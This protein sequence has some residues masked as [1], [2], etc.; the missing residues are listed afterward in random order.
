MPELASRWLTDAER[1]LG[2][3]HK[4]RR[5][6]WAELVEA[7]GVC[8]ARCRLPILPGQ[9]W[10]LGHV[11]GSNRQLEAGPEHRH[12]RDCPE[13]GNRATR[14]RPQWR[15][16]EW[17]TVVA[18]PGP[19][20]EGLGEGDE[21]WRVPW[22]EPLLKVPA[23][24]TW[25]RFM[26]VPHPRAVGSLGDEFAAF[27]QE[28]TGKPLRWWQRLV[29]TRL[30]EHDAAGEL[31]WEWLV[32]STAR[33][34]GKSWLLREICLWRIHQAERFGEPQDVVH[35]GKDVAICREIQ[36]EARIWAKQQ[37]SGWKVREVN[38]QEQIERL[39][40]GS[41]WMV[42]AKAAVQ[43]MSASMAV[44]DEAWAVLPTAID[45]ALYP[46]MV[47]KAQPQLLLVSTAHRLATSLVLNRRAQALAG[48]E[49][50]D[51]DLILEWS[52]PPARD[53]GDMAGWRQASPHWTPRR[54]RLVAKQLAAA[55]SGEAQDPDEPDPEASFRCQWLNQWP[56]KLANAEAKTE[57]LL[58]AGLWQDLAA[59]VVTDTPV[60]V[61]V[62]DNFGK[63]AAVG[64][65]APVGD[66]RF[67]VDGQEFPDWD[68]AIAWVERLAVFRQIREMH[69]GASLEQKVPRDWTLPP[70]QLVG[71]V[72]ERTGLAVF[73]DLANSGML[74]HDDTPELDGA[75]L[76]AQ[77]RE[78]TS[79][80]EVATSP[81]HLVKAVVFAVQAAHKP[82]RLYAV[83]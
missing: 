5:K 14:G 1:G 52:C 76:S 49:V 32:L 39:A 45:D 48:L 79:G 17:K 60:V 46:T 18:E 11:D 68:T 20:R 41:R 55:R 40:D 83:R 61:A 47:A 35:T 15:R 67:E 10:D 38:G 77:V 56:R 58:P 63:G 22:L 33:Q 29:A 73:R 64:V 62:E 43:G 21:R 71:R 6:G 9:A 80:L 13:G 81:R 36:R 78:L 25:P 30:L 72:E 26:T 24:A 70:A 4:R 16:R 54:E 53:L 27:A 2:T 12:A 82:A 31:V 75:V 23:D 51:G 44:V 69:I 7:G 57:P 74:V 19:E 3:E 42:R 66:G 8:C 28:R 59:A 65:V 34:L 50:G 37:E